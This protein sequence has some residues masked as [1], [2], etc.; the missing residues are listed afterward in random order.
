MDV[1][2]SPSPDSS[3]EGRPE[4]SWTVGRLLTWTTDFLKRRGSES[5]RLDAEVMLA[6]VL[7]WQRVQLYTHFTEE[8]G[9]RPRG[10]FRELVRRRA[11]GA[12]VAYLVRRK[13]FYSLAFAVS[14]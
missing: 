6:H 7:G 4:E 2:Q 9:E 12:P 10:Q 5:P 14:A 11:A 8:V 13:E 1:H 3:A